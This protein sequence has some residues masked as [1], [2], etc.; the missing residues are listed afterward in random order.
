MEW[1]TSAM[2]L[3]FPHMAIFLYIIL[4]KSITLPYK[5]FKRLTITLP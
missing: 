4:F 1:L 3:I 5:M 2:Q